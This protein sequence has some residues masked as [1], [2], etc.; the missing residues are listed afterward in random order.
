MGLRINIKLADLAAISSVNILLKTEVLPADDQFPAKDCLQAE[1]SFVINDEVKTLIFDADFH[2]GVG[3][4][5]ADFNA[6][7][8]SRQSIQEMVDQL[9]VAYS[10]F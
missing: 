10:V 3:S 8:A 1:V 9:A 2:E 5:S 7:G 6:W 4:L